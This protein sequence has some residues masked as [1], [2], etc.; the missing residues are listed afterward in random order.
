MQVKYRNFAFYRL[1]FLLKFVP[2]LHDSIISSHIIAE[3]SII[4]AKYFA[5]SKLHVAGFQT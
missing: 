2:S 4:L 3:L 5:F 1:L